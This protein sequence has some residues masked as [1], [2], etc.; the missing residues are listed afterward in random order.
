MSQ[1]PPAVSGLEPALPSSW[2]RSERMFALEKERIFCREWLCVAR[3]EELAEPGSWRML[4]VLGE[5]ILLLRNRS[6][7]LHGFYN[8]CRHRGARL[9]REAPL[10]GAAVRLPGG[11]AAGRITCP[12]HQWTYDFDG[13]LVAAPHLTTGDSFDATQFSLYPVGLACW[14]GF[15]F[16]HLTPSAA[17]PLAQQLGAVP[18]TF[19]G[20]DVV[21][22]IASFV[23]E[24]GITHII[25]GRTLRPWYRRWFGQSVLDRLLREIPKVDVVVVQNQE[26]SH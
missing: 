6:N 26:L 5:S 12:Y 18:M 16:V 21:S 17:V 23:H 11:I 15:V 9:C 24:Y 25:M 13:R 2:Y 8:V 19:K 20:R 10:A 7:E 1:L 4:D 14:G 3:E 22:A